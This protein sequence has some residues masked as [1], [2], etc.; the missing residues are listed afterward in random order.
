MIEIRETRLGRVLVSSILLGFFG[1][2]FWLTDRSLGHWLGL[3][4]EVAWFV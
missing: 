4:L 1:L 2:F 3:G